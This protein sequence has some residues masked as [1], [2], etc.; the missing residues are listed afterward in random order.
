M[1]DVFCPQQLRCWEQI[2]SQIHMLQHWKRRGAVVLLETRTR[3]QRALPQRVNCS[4]WRVRASCGEAIGFEAVSR[5][6]TVRRT[7][8]TLP[9]CPAVNT[10]WRKLLYSGFKTSFRLQCLD[11]NTL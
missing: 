2:I 8:P 10:M 5:P 6:H 9:W 3:T 11:Q 4:G 7:R 1:R